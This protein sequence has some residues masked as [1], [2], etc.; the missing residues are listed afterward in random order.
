[1]NLIDFYNL[2]SFK[3]KGPEEVNTFLLGNTNLLSL[4][5]DTYPH[6]EQHFGKGTSVILEVVR[7]PEIPNSEQLV[8]YIQS[9]KEVEDALACLGRLDLDWWLEASASYGDKIC[10]H[11]E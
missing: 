1:M 9:D 6:I 2:E 8:A 11:L 10:L 7:D 5:E 4:L 3:I